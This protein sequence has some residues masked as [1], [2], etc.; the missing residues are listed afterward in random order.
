[1]T[2]SEPY[3]FDPR[4]LFVPLGTPG[5]TT[6]YS[7]NRPAVM[8]SFHRSANVPPSAPANALM[9]AMCFLLVFSRKRGCAAMRVACMTAH[10]PSAQ[11]RS[12]S[13]AASRDCSIRSEPPRAYGRTAARRIP[14]RFPTT[15]SRRCQARCETRRTCPSTYRPAP[16]CRVWPC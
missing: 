12:V 10:P 15:A 14:H 4:P 6:T 3:S 7:S 5:A 2:P 8:M 11:V 1:M 9:I 13:S 16:P